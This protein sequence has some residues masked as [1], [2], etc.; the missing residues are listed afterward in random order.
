M[1]PKC[2]RKSHNKLFGIK[3]MEKSKYSNDKQ[4][5]LLE[6]EINIMRKLSH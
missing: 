6:N 4:L 3:I 2:K 5:L 1:V